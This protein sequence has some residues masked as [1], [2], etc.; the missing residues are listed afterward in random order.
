M[1]S[2]SCLAVAAEAAERVNAMLVAKGKLKINGV[3]GRSSGDLFTTE[4]EINDAPLPARN[5]LT[6]GIFQEEIC[7]STGAVMST[8]G[9][10]MSGV[11][12]LNSGSGDRALYLHVQAPT[13][14]A[15]ENV[16]FVPGSE[17]SDDGEL[18]S[19]SGDDE[20]SSKANIASARQWILLGVD[21]AKP[22]R[23]PFLAIPGKTF[24]VSSPGD[25]MEYIQQFLDDELI[26]LVVDETNRQ[27]AENGSR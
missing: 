21:P 14:D 3:T 1:S 6:K 25:L 7:R 18:S 26:S 2:K 12:K 15:I 17:E 11:E 19:S 9:R 8:R 13:V 4:V 20:D 24:N 16:Y 27:A 10:Y 5:V 23:F 22:P